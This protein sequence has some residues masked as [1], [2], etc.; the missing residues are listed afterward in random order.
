MAIFSD[1][2]L[3]RM[4]VKPEF[5][6]ILLNPSSTVCLKER[7]CVFAELTCMLPHS[8][9]NFSSPER[10][11]LGPKLKK[12]LLTDELRH[13]PVSWFC[14]LDI[15]FILLLLSAVPCS[16]VPFFAAV[17]CVSLAHFLSLSLYAL[18]HHSLSDCEIKAFF[19]FLACVF[20][21][22]LFLYCQIKDLPGHGGTEMYSL[23]ASCAERLCDMGIFLV[24]WNDA[25]KLASQSL[26][27][28]FDRVFHS[29]HSDR[30][31]VVTFYDSLLKTET[32]ASAG[33][34]QTFRSL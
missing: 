21:P 33:R 1:E 4:L 12:L 31:V 5:L 27:C 15:L 30:I 20:D 18:L 11:A 9:F 29:A 26:C 8:E 19:V 24:S 34:A 3:A 6:T 7:F 22:C 10:L 25:P 13:I 23:S 17:H 2:Q 14:L 16:V 28:D 32:R